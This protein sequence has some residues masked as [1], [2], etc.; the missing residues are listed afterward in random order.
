[1]KYNEYIQELEDTLIEALE[2]HDPKVVKKFLRTL[3]EAQSRDNNDILH[4]IELLAQQMSSFQKEMN[5][6]FESMQKEMN[7]RFESIQKEMNARFESV[8]KRIGMMMW[9]IGIGFTVITV[10][11]GLVQF[12]K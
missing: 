10:F 4:S 1:M 5:T 7:V 6:R 12:I 8:D 9:F 2:T 11:M 3:T